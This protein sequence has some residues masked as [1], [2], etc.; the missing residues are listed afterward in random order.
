MHIKML[1]SIRYLTKYHQNIFVKKFHFL[2]NS[3]PIIFDNFPF[4]IRLVISYMRWILKIS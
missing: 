4:K 1:T 2:Q 3:L